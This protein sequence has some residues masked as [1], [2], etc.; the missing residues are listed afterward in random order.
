MFQYN[1]AYILVLEYEYWYSRIG[2]DATA[3]CTYRLDGPSA[4]R[5][6]CAL[7]TR[8]TVAPVFVRSE[9]TKK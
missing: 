9:Q 8:H 3:H 7:C 6:D 2:I 5:L 4:V 1:M